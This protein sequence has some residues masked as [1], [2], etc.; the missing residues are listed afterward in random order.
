MMLY[1]DCERRW[2]IP[3]RYFGGVHCLVERDVGVFLRERKFAVPL[4][5]EVLLGGY[6]S[7]IN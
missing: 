2:V 4:Q 1:F 7:D 5:P 6:D 3:V